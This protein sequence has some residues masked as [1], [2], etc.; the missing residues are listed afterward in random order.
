[1]QDLPPVSS[2]TLQGPVERR[3]RA[4]RMA[5]IPSGTCAGLQPNLVIRLVRS[6]WAQRVISAAPSYEAFAAHC[7]PPKGG[8]FLGTG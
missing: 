1:M 6:Q 4:V 2:A 7:F 8:Q 3:D 5:Q